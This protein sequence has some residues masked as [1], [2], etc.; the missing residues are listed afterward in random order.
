M[1]WLSPHHLFGVAWWASS[2]MQR[3]PE[4]DD[5]DQAKQRAERFKAL[6][7]SDSYKSTEKLLES[8]HKRTFDMPKELVAPPRIDHLIHMP[9]TPSEANQ[10][11]SAG[12]LV[13]RLAETV[14]RWRKLAQTNTQPVVI[15]VLSNGA[16]INV[17]LL[18]EES[19]HGIR[20]EGT[21]D[22]QPC[23]LLTH[24]ASIQLLCLMAKVEQK[25]PIG[26]II[27]GQRT[28]A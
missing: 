11:Q 3:R 21:I 28:D 16:S 5:V 2:P 17:E 10:F 25:R 6:V 19:F 13:R 1:Q 9:P 26:F 8:M 22:G 20:V 24:Q 15:A 4:L 12:V 14:V 7:E 27:A 23:M 18:A